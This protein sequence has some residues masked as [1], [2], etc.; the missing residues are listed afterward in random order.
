MSVDLH[1][2][3]REKCGPDRMPFSN[4][5]SDRIEAQYYLFLCSLVV[6]LHYDSDYDMNGK[7][8]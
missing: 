6:F 2:H 1:L 4:S 5:Y 7:D 3:G 8:S